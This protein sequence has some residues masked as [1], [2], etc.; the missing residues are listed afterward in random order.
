M[1]EGEG[2]REA[3]YCEGKAKEGQRCVEKTRGKDAV[4]RETPRETPWTRDSLVLLEQTIWLR[5]RRGGRGAAGKR[6]KE[7][8]QERKEEGG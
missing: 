2:E 1:R 6:R 5:S 3:K 4:Q 8:K 7:G